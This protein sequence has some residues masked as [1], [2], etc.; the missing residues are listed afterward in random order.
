MKRGGLMVTFLIFF[1]EALE[2]S[3]L[4]SLFVAYLT[5]IGQGNRFKDVWKGLAAGIAASVVVGVA[6]YFTIHDY[7]G[8]SL[9]LQTEGVCYLLACGMLTYFAVWIKNNHD[10]TDQL[11][12][13]IESV[14]ETRSRFAIS[15]FI[16]LSV[17]R[18]GIEVVV[19]L[20]PLMVITNPVLNVVQ[21]VFGIIF[22]AI[23]GYL[24]YV[25]GKNIPLKSLL[26]IAS[27]LIVMV[28]AG[29]LAQGLGEFQQLGWLPF[30]NGIVWDTTAIM[31]NESIVGGVF[32]GLF[33]Y[34]DKPT[35]LQVISYFLYLCVIG[36]LT[37][38]RKKS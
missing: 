29:F 15:G 34:T 5:L 23:C 7:V 1:R 9:Q 19:F 32:H 11:H 13:T 18:E 37:V 22:G 16:F 17:F 24:V 30:G 3:M 2:A 26:S 35:S 25:L 4:C 36:C 27:V 14:V 38:Y 12:S 8:S 21:A 31:S 28:A 20:L 10:S 6:V 33:G